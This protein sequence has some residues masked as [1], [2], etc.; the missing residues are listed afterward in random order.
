MRR[1]RGPQALTAW[2]VVVSALLGARPAPAPAVPLPPLTP[3]TQGQILGVSDDARYVLTHFGFSSTTRTVRL[4]DRLSGTTVD[5][6]DAVALSGNGQATLSMTNGLTWTDLRTGRS[7]S[8]DLSGIGSTALA[9]DAG[10]VPEPSSPAGVFRRSMSHDGRYVLFGALGADSASSTWRWDTTTGAIAAVAAA[11]TRPVTITPDGR[12]ALVIRHTPCQAVG[13]DCPSPMVVDMATAREFPIPGLWTAYALSA[14]GRFVFGVTSPV[15]VFGYTPAN[16]LVRFDRTSRETLDLGSPL[17]GTNFQMSDDGA[18]LAFM[19]Q[20]AGVPAEF[21]T[22]VHV[23]DPSPR[24]VGGPANYGPAWLSGDGSELIMLHLTQTPGPS[25][26]SQSFE[27]V[28][29]PVRSGAPRVQ[30]GETVSLAL[31]GRFGIPT[32]AAAV[33]LNVT[34]TDPQH[35][36]YVTVFPCGA[37][38]PLASNVNHVA[39]QTVPNAVIAKLDDQGRVCLFTKAHANL[40]VD[41]VGWFPAGSS[42]HALPPARLLDTREAIGIPSTTPLAAGQIVRVQVTGRGGVA[43]DARTAVL[44]VTVTDPDAAGFVTAFPCS[45][46]PPTA[47]NLNYTAGRTV[48]NAVV[49]RLDDGGGACLFTK[50]AAH[51]V[52]DVSAYIGAEPGFG[53]LDPQRLLDTRDGSRA[54]GGSVT[55]VHV[56]GRGAVPADASAVVLNVTATGPAAAGYLTVYPCTE[57]VPGASTV[58]YVAGDTVPNL[59][60]AAL[61]AL[62]DVCVFTQSATHLVVDVSGAIVGP[63]SYV[64]MEPVRALD[65]RAPA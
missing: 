37:E 40:V 2:F 46:R 58:N 8:A 16:R 60:I 63:S 42:L 22:V 33:A 9:F 64:G 65:T 23:P 51:L 49:A 62:G 56:A 1:Q 6:P 4:T 3:G 25:G 19:G 17:L 61:D 38:L 50:G 28:G 57:T 48:A 24:V 43:G 15:P 55:R 53:G 47:S 32:D 18:I 27:I 39:A 31:A 13:H 11:P 5:A 10:S 12:H 59:A 52:V 21:P 20:A 34:V 41:A 26:V 7:T 36:G 29:R 45:S 54:A 30:A 14:D 44:N 35:A